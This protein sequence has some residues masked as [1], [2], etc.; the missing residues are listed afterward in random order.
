ME[1]IFLQVTHN[2]EQ[3]DAAARIKQ[4][5]DAATRLKQQKFGTMM[6]EPLSMQP[7]EEVVLAAVILGPILEK[8]GFGHPQKN[9]S[10]GNCTA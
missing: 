6:R 5:F 2:G 7:G 8:I 3:F 9:P 10:T 1:R 4:Q